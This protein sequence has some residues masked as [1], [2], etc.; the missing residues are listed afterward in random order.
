MS[1]RPP[2]RAYTFLELLGHENINLD[3]KRSQVNQV[4]NYRLQTVLPL[5][6]RHQCNIRTSHQRAFQC[7]KFMCSRFE[8]TKKYGKSSLF[9]N[10]LFEDPKLRLSSNLMFWISKKFNVV[11]KL[12]NVRQ[13]QENSK[14]WEFTVI[15]IFDDLDS[16]NPMLRFL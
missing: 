4:R 13:Q 6:F 8:T 14:Y 16:K 5:R 2:L 7:D 11:K 10:P 12:L 15:Q 9:T 1:D 3:S